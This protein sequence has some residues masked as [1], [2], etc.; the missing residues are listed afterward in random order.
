MG[1][2]KCL[3]KYFTKMVQVWSRRGKVLEIYRKSNLFYIV[4]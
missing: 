3:G 1:N 4:V 2:N